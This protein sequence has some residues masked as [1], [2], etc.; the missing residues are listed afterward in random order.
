MSFCPAA[1]TTRR[2]N[3]LGTFSASLLAGTA[4]MLLSVSGAFA[5]THTVVQNGEISGE[6]YLNTDGDSL[7]VEKGGTITSG[8]GSG[9]YSNGGGGNISVDIDNAGT[10]LVTP[11]G[12]T[13]IYVFNGSSIGSL[14]NQIGGNIEAGLVTIN[15]ADG[16]DLS[17][18][19]NAGSIVS[20]NNTA[21]SLTGAGNVSGLHNLST[22]LIRGY[23]FG[24]NLNGNDLTNITNAGSI[25]GLTEAAFR[26]T[27]ISL[28][29][30]SNLSTGVIR[31]DTY[32]IHSDGANLF[33][34]TNAGSI[35]G[36]TEDAIFV[37]AAN[38]TGLSNLTTGVIHGSHY[39]INVI[40]DLTDFNNAGTVIADETSNI[41]D[42]IAIR[43]NAIVNLVNS[44]SIIGTNAGTSQG[45]AILGTAI[46]SLV[47]S[48][49]I[50]ADLG[51][52]A[53]Q[54]G[55]GLGGDTDL[56]LLPGSTIQGGIDI[57][58]VV[59]D[60]DRLFVGNGLNLA[61]T[62]E[63]ALPDAIETYG[64][65]SATNGMLVA[66]ADTSALAA[67]D[68]TLSDTT[69]AISGVLSGE[70]DQNHAQSDQN[71]WL[72]G[73]GSF[74]R[75]RADGQFAGANHLFSGALAGADAMYGEMQ[76][77]LFAGFSAGV[78]GV[79]VENGQNIN[80]KGF[81]AGAYGRFDTDAFYLDFGLTG[82]IATNDSER[83]V[84]NNLI[85]GG[86]ETASASF[87]SY[88]IAPEITIG[89]EVGMGEYN[90]KP[91]ATLRYGIV[92]SNGYTE[93]GSVAPLSVGART[94]QV[95]DARLQVAMPMEIAGPNTMFE[96]KTGIDGRLVI[97][98]DF[99]ATLLGTNTPGFNPG[100]AQSSIG[101]FAGAHLAHVI[102]DTAT[103]F[104]STELGMGT[105]T[106]FR[107]D[108]EVGVKVRF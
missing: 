87:N 54:E 80:S 82:G 86:L 57:Y 94:S 21:I 2:P 37:D 33:N 47:N 8:A 13:G 68:N 97:G 63:N 45:G 23:T 11:G 104:A 46:T 75:S 1:P 107:A 48:G 96:L 92:H 6:I 93:T 67:Q 7:T 53:I 29:G 9:V 18:L 108:A 100:G 59:G 25:I 62:F 52:S 51:G 34:I 38:L 16:G 40:G 99:D 76:L 44:G 89:T 3:V 90:L 19:T 103:L 83:S 84:A 79:A 28:T 78:L 32:G 50:F 106:T 88:F 56:T 77:G 20:R 95:I 15:V 65:L 10:I 27:G 4:L 58:T 72:K 81:F 74:E 70:L 12:G 43:A 49:R 55:G 73:F 42:T 71:Y 30:L 26:V 91:S 61:T 17:N 101:G 64:A 22:G 105:E 66:V 102:S 36:L 60:M 69:S 14:T 5:Q 85:L 35:I 24:M 41:T 98:G 39:S 31:G